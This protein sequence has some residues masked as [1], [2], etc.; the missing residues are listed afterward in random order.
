MTN[1]Q[2]REDFPEQLPVGIWAK[3]LPRK[4]GTLVVKHNYSNDNTLTKFEFELS[5]FFPVTFFVNVTCRKHNVG[6]FVPEHRDA[7]EP[8]FGYTASLILHNASRGGQF[9]CEQKALK[10]GRLSVFNG[11]RHLHSV[12]P[13]EEGSRDLL[14]GSIYFAPWPAPITKWR[15]RASRR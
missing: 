1:H 5:I 3:C 8:I 11:S 14:L 6:S 2:V 7:F 12:T 13:I 9:K 10:F 4:I 15:R